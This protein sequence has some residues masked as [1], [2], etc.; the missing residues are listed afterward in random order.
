MSTRRHRGPN[1]AWAFGRDFTC[2]A[3]E[4]CEAK[5]TAECAAA[6]KER[7][8]CEE[9]ERKAHKEKEAKERTVTDHGTPSKERKQQ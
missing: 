8:G 1:E 7:E 2:K 4:E 9:R 5:L 6:K 3:K